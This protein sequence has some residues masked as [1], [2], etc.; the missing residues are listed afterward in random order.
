MDTIKEKI[1]FFHEL[2]ADEQA[3]VRGYVAEHPEWQP[4]LAHA[5]GLTD[6]LRAAQ[7]LTAEP[8]TQDMLAHLLVAQALGVE[9]LPSAMAEACARA[10]EALATDPAYR[11]HYETLVARLETLT[12]ETD[13][14]AHV[15]RLSGHTVASAPQGTAAPPASDRSPTRRNRPP[16]PVRLALAATVSLLVVYGALWGISEL[17]T[18]A[19]E[20]LAAID[21][22]ELYVEGFGTAAVR[23]GNDAAADA[24][25]AAPSPDALYLKAL[26]QLR[27]A[28]TSVLG[29]F[30]RY[31]DVALSEAERLL[32]EVIAAE[33]AGSFVQLDAYYFLGKIHLAR[34]DKPE[35]R[36][37]LLRVVRG[38]GR[39]A[40]AASDILQYLAADEAYDPDAS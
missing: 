36:D 10:E 23:S 26:K 28:R 6:L 19:H 25:P 24:A 29:L 11:E 17:T 12:A 8:P 2:P 31:D 1:L 15:E 13:P 5:Q 14:V 40:P 38:E 22:D 39:N 4:V 18:P 32:G 34:G 20:R 30:P 33:D 21:A 27:E 16:Q 9:N 7:G 3:D 35:A 37:A